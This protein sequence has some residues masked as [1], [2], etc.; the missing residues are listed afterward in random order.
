MTI[1]DVDNCLDLIDQALCL[2]DDK[3]YNPKFWADIY[4]KVRSIENFLFML[5]N[6]GVNIE[7]IPIR[8]YY[9]LQSI[10]CDD[11]TI[12][13]LIDEVFEAYFR[14]EYVAYVNRVLHGETNE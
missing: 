10:K 8:V 7:D 6:T 14:P 11:E 2:I 4:D 5:K 9:T 12:Q 13:G 1:E 3:N